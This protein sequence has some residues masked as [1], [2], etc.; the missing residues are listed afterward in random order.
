VPLGRCGVAANGLPA[1]STGSAAWRRPALP[2]SGST[3][4]A[5]ERLYRLS[6]AAALPA[7]PPSAR[8]CRIAGGVGATFAARDACG[9]SGT[10]LEAVSRSEAERLT[11]AIDI[12]DLVD[13]L[14]VLASDADS[15]NAW[16]HPCGWT[17]NE[18]FEHLQDHPPC[19]PIAELWNSFDDLWPARRSTLAPV[20][21][22]ELDDALTRLCT[23]FEQ[24][25]GAAF[26]DKLETLDRPEW[27]RVRQ[28]AAHARGLA[29][30]L[31]DEKWDDAKSETTE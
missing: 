13:H 30:A 17:R 10:Y 8:S 29:E 25:D 11:R 3:G 15:Q 1:G 16:L 31:A 28:L 18:P 2:R 6:R 5:A 27:D 19:M 7:L 12:P 20:L 4:F 21:T 26:I 9:L 14:S 22:P 23:A 24:L